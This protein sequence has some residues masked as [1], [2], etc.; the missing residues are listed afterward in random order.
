MVGSGVTE[1]NIT[2]YMTANGIIIGSHLKQ[3]GLWFN[4][5]DPIRVTQVVA[6]VS[7]KRDQMQAKAEAFGTTP[8]KFKAMTA[9]GE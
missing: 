3:H 7:K 8:D 4:D 1:E 5:I 2:K 6:K 9:Q